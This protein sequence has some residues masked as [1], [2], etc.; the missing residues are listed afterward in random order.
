MS[1]DRTCSETLIHYIAH[2]IPNIAQ[3]FFVVYTWTAA[4]S[5]FTSLLT[6]LTVHELLQ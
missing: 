4:I 5:S 6:M 1:L 3:A 2:Y